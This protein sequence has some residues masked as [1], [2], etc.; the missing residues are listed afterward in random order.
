MQ[1]KEVPVALCIDAL[2]GQGI[3]LLAP[4]AIDFFDEREDE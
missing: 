2:D 1:E 4:A 3:A